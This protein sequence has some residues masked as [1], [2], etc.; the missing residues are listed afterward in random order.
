MM[1]AM[2][3]IGVELFICL[4]VYAFNRLIGRSV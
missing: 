3:F 1:M 4:I 2:F